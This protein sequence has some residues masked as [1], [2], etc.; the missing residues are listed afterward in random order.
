MQLLDTNVLLWFWHGDAQMG[1]VARRAVERAWQDG[2]GGRIRDLVLG[3]L[4]A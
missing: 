1:P 4:H 2:E 3:S